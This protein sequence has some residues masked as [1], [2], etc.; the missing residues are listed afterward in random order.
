VAAPLVAP[1][2]PAP[3]GDRQQVVGYRT[4]NPWQVHP[5]LRR[6][7]NCVKNHFYSKLRKAVR[8]LN[9][10]IQDHFDSDGYKAIG[11]GML[12]KIIEI[13]ESKFKNNSKEDE[14]FV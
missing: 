8:K 11:N 9:K 12:S 6:S 13:T 14:E 4:E 10:V 2:V 5:S 3:R 7:D 1:P